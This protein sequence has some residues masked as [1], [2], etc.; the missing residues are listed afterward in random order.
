MY[1][2]DS[3]N[4]IAPQNALPGLESSYIHTCSTQKVVPRSSML[5]TTYN[6]NNMLLDKYFF[7]FFWHKKKCPISSHW[8][9]TS[10]GP[11]LPLVSCIL[12]CFY[13]FPLFKGHFELNDQKWCIP[14]IVYANTLTWYIE[15]LVYHI[16][17]QELIVQIKIALFNLLSLISYFKY[18]QVNKWN[19]C[20]LNLTLGSWMHMW[21]KHRLAF[22]SINIQLVIPISQIQVFTTNRKKMNTKTPLMSITTFLA[23]WKPETASF[24]PNATDAS[25]L[26]K[27]TLP[28]WSNVNTKNIKSLTILVLYMTDLHREKMLYAVEHRSMHAC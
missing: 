2:F 14:N 11:S 25:P 21:I 20:Y 16:F 18:I 22:N 3:C 13:N 10:T 19:F 5:L 27:N 15:F 28:F 8:K 9:R 7:L 12:K 17:K 23:H 24:D 6:T 1:F 26:G 4:G